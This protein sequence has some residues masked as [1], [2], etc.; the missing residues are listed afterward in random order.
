M[1]GKLAIGLMSGTSCD[2][3]D[4]ALVRIEG[5][6]TNTKVD[7]VDFVTL[8]YSQALKEELLRLASGSIGGS[9]D[10]SRINF[11]LGHIA[12]DASLAVCRKAGVS[13]SDIS[14]I[15]SHG[16]TLY[17]EP[18]AVSTL[19]YKVASTFQVGEASV[20][21]ETFGCP[22]VSDFRVRDVA[23]GGQ[24]APL[25][26]YT[27][28]LLFRSEEESIALQNI[29]GIGNV[30]ILPAGCSLDDIMAFD[31]GPGNMVI[32]A[33]V[34]MYTNGKYGFDKDG[35][36]AKKGKVNQKLLQFMCDD[37][38]LSKAPPKSTGRERYGS[39]YI[40]KLLNKAGELN[41]Q[42]II[43]TATAYTAA[44][45]RIGL[46]YFSHTKP[47]RLVVSGGGASN[48]TLMDDI[49]ME[50]PDVKVMKNPFSDSKEAVAFAVLANE[51][52]CNSCSNAVKATG[53]SHPV[54]LGKVSI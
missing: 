42:D 36:I 35:A 21:N 53:A 33:L 51:R 3:M 8:E 41:M 4:A 38:Y 9:C 20:L 37:P 30:T 52:L 46:E 7:L 47:D 39:E 28:Y 14:F 16:H 26:P 49:C 22:V 13:H 27:E 44:S 29:G 6:S 43:A 40:L 50:L 17:H 1:N 19:G 11:I 31:T 5:C 10:I 48:K 2:G 25:V 45:I 23:A 54:V 18:N 12:C 15:G 32:D 24:G 34:C